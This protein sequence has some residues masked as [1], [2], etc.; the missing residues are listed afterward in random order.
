MKNLQYLATEIY[1]VK[2]CLYPEIMKDV[3]IFQENQ[4]DNVRS[5]T[6]L[7]IEIYIQRILELTL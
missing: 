5:G 1:K 3:F 6:H 4:N 7:A 2:N